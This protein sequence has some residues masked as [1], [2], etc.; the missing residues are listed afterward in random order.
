MKIYQYDTNKF[1]FKREIEFLFKL[2]DLSSINENKDLQKLYNEY[3]KSNSFLNIYVQFINEYI[4]PLYNNVP[5]AYQTTP[6]GRIAYKN[7]LNMDVFHKDKWYRQNTEYYDL[8]IYNIFLPFTDAFESNTIWTESIEDKRDFYPLNC[9]YGQFVHWDGAN[10]L[11]GNVYNKTNKTRIS[12]DFR[13]YEYK[14]TLSP[15]YTLLN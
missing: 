6:V 3:L 12:I 14:D 7:K 11:H 2:N 9:N 8:Q 1:D 10:L 4:K 15:I 5:I 13:I